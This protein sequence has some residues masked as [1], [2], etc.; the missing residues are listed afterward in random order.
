MGIFYKKMLSFAAILSSSLY[1]TSAVAQTYYPAGM[2]KQKFH[3]WLDAADSTQIV[4]DSLFRW[5]DKIS[6]WQARSFSSSF[7]PTYTTVNGKKTVEFNGVKQLFISTQPSPTVFDSAGA[8]HLAQVV[9]LY[10]N[11]DT[12]VKDFRI[13]TYSRNSSGV[14]GM[15]V[16]YITN[17]ARFRGRIPGNNTSAYIGNGNSGAVDL[18]NNWALLESFANSGGTTNHFGL[19]N[20]V[21]YNTYSMSS[22]KLS[23]VP[24]FIGNRGNSAALPTN[25]AVNVHWAISE[26]VLSSSSLGITGRKLLELYLANKWTTKTL[27]PAALQT[28]YQ[29]V[30][31]I[32][33]N[34][35]IG[36][37][38][39][40][41]TDSINATASGN[42][43]QLSNVSFLKNTGDYVIAADNKASGTVALDANFNRWARAWYVQRTDAMVNGGNI[44]MNFDFN[45]YGVVADTATFNYYLLFNDK[46]GSFSTGNNWIVPTINAV[47]NANKWSVELPSANFMS[48]FYTVVWAPKNT[49]LNLLPGF[50][51]PT[52]AYFPGGLDKTN[53]NI[54]L[55]ASD[56]S[57]IGYEGGLFKWVDKING[58]AFKAPLATHNPADSTING[59]KMVYFNGVKGLVLNPAPAIFDSAT[60]YHLAQIVQ[61]DTG[62]STTITD[63]RYGTF[64]RNSDAPGISINYNTTDKRFRLRVPANSVWSYVGGGDAAV[65]DVRG[66]VSLMETYAATGGLANYVGLL[67]GAY[68][69][70][71]TMLTKKLTNNPI[72][73]GNRGNTNSA[74]YSYFVNV[75]W[76]IS[77]TVLTNIAL[78]TPAKKIVETYLAYKWGIQ[79]NLST[80]T[81]NNYL[82]VNAAFYNNIVG[83][84]RERG[85]DS[86]TASVSDNGLGIENVNT[87]DGFLKEPGD[88]ILLGDNLLS[89]IQQIGNGFA[90]WNRVWFIQKNDACGGYGGLYKLKFNFTNYGLAA[91]ADTTLFD[92]HLL[93]NATDPTF[94]TGSNYVIPATSK[95]LVNNGS[96]QFIFT[97]DAIN[98]ATGYYTLVYGKKNTAVSGNINN[99]A[100]F[101]APNIT[102]NPAPTITAVFAGNKFNYLNWSSE[103]IDYQ[104]GYYKIYVKRNNGAFALLDSVAANG[105]NYYAHRNLLNDSTY[106]Y[107]VTA[108]I[109]S[110]KESV[111]SAAVAAIPGVKQASW[112]GLPQFAGNATALV[113]G[114]KPVAFGQLKYVF[115]KNATSGAGYQADYTATFNALAPNTTYQ[116]RYKY[117]DSV[118][119]TA[120]ESAWSSNAAFVLKDSLQGGFTYNMS[121]FDNTT[122]AAPNGIGPY[123]MLPMQQDTTGLRFIKHVPPVGTHPRIFC[124]P[125]DST[126]IKWRLQN[127][128]SGKAAYK[129]FHAHTILLQW[130]AP[131]YKSTGWYNKDTMGVPFITNVGYTNVK[132]FYDSLAAGDI[133]VTSNYAN[134]FGGN[135]LKIAFEL[136]YE[137]FECWLFKGAVDPVTN[138]SYTTRAAKLANAMTIW[139]RKAIADTNV[140]Y[141]NRAYFG[142]QYAALIYDFLHSQMT[143]TQQDTV[144]MALAKIACDSNE[145]HGF[146]AISYAST[147]N[148]L[149]FGYEIIPNLAIE[150]EA[151]YTSSYNTAIKRWARNVWNFLSYGMYDK[152][153][154]FFE[155]NG[156][157]QIN[158][159]LLYI[160]ARRGYSMLGHPSVRSHATKFLPAITQPFGFSFLGM[161]LLGGTGSRNTDFAEDPAYGGWRFNE[162][163]T[164]ALKWVYPKDTAVDFVWKNYIQRQKASRPYNNTYY[165]YSNGNGNFSAGFY[166]HL[167]AVIFASDYMPI[168]FAQQAQI[169]MN[170]EKMY[171]DS[172]G[173][174]ACLRSG[175]DTTSAALWFHNKTDLGGHTFANKND[176]VYSALGRIFIARNTTNSNGH[177]DSAALTRSNSG[178][179]IN[180]QGATS[181]LDAAVQPVP[182]KIPMVI[183][184]SNML[185][186]AGDATEA[187]SDI[188][189]R[190][191]GGWEGD[192]PA[193]TLPGASKV[194]TTPNSYRFSPYYSF[195]E[196]PFY[197]SYAFTDLPNTTTYYNRL[198]K[199]TI[200]PVKKVFRTVALLQDAKPYVLIADDVQK[201]SLVNNYKWIAQ[202]AQD[203]TFLSSS[204]NL[205]DS[206]YRN[207]VIYQEPVAT[208]NR[209][210]LIR[211]LNNTGAVAGL[212]VYIDSINVAKRVGRWVIE[213]NSISP[214]FRIML[215]A[216]NQGDSL[217][218]TKWND[219]AHTSLTVINNGTT[220]TILFNI[221]AA[222]RT[223]ILLA[224]GGGS[225]MANT[226]PS[227]YVKAAVNNNAVVQLNWQLKSGVPVVKYEVERMQPQG[228]AFVSYAVLHNLPLT[229]QFTDEQPLA[230]TVYR[231]KAWLLNGKV[232]Y[233][234]VVQA[235]P[236]P[237]TVQVVPN[238]AH[239]NQATYLQCHQLPAGNY[240][241]TIAN[242]L[243][244]LVA[245]QNI[246][247]ASAA[248]N[249]NIPIAHLGRLPK[250]Q[251]FLVLSGGLLQKQLSLLVQ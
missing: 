168:G 119:G 17:D 210:F 45:Q 219:A 224:T 49:N 93:Y 66:K 138:T 25:Y 80:N 124:N 40:S 203:L 185:S 227:L 242:A 9:Y 83:I 136:S 41:S 184:N 111:K 130:G 209:R 176:I 146:E 135:S 213:S 126:D 7:N 142:G 19:L 54:W 192:N 24:V 98:T 61:V 215:F 216:Y 157:D 90:R 134:Q 211:V 153:G 52:F 231:I 165:S 121:D 162:M 101:I 200:N 221:D 8:Y 190:Q 99:G 92:Y 127:T 27:I 204:V 50:M 57:T 84:G 207:D 23:G 4:I 226:E 235:T 205:V 131:T 115:E 195:D 212:P 129:F 1:V 152:T 218:I 144:R 112:V 178:I 75:K 214:Q 241:V 91:N 122:I 74:P 220:R 191:F 179:L 3:L 199:Q 170:N 248:T 125:E 12:S 16:N 20:G 181:G 26:T 147:T 30:D 10:N 133:G 166:F 32:F 87:V 193:I 150:G 86:V 230:Q 217:P 106:S 223:N 201:D 189:Y 56:A 13:G 141:N 108:V 42:G 36:I 88:Y 94:A 31:T 79:N 118:M 128:N 188:W 96:T 159:T 171:F 206:N 233:S 22:V 249:S 161:G 183:K 247:I 11:I 44:A 29:P 37:G 236:Q 70:D 64:C 76:G 107:Q 47:F 244:K 172:L 123:A 149:T 186:I 245:Q 117:M 232:V 151:G 167:P 110:G 39:E 2:A 139:A 156:K 246:Q 6:G 33:S 143:P 68:E 105:N 113:R 251:Y 18:R 158:T 239:T 5:N 89:G 72:A 137:A 51:Q 28:L 169:A 202:K 38:Y 194:M 62:L 53:F 65:P 109:A 187:Y 155:S 237:F 71:Y 73:L 222:G 59:K 60:G 69:A 81:V 250:G 55:D 140:N 97:V 21:Q 164:P 240:T 43:L 173:G 177:Y 163:E 154:S 175:F 78:K 238:P 100:T 48:G 145:L 77:E 103:K 85:T 120:S 234:N 67:N 196:I 104:I 174:L 182:G 63:F 58:F 228:G 148:W 180:N 243:G 225:R 34:N 15:S 116:F 114:I 46:S 160:V 95:Q 208:G 229:A 35:L 132:P 102:I 198:V 197:N 82:P 14:P